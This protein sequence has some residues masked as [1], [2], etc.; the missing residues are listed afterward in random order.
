MQRIT[1]VKNSVI[2]KAKQIGKFYFI[3]DSYITYL[4]FLKIHFE[5]YA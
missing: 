5:C 3:T 4:K 1:N 2:G